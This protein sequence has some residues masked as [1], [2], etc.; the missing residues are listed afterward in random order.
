MQKVLWMLMQPSELS[1]VVILAIGLGSQ[2]W[3]TRRPV[4]YI[5]SI[6]VEVDGDDGRNVPYRGSMHQSVQLHRFNPISQL[7]HQPVPRAKRE[8]S[9][10]DNITVVGSFSPL[11]R[12][13]AY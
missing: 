6:I 13:C 5:H 8:K 2:L 7:D 9:I 12:T 3:L 11:P 1:N 10:A 4:P